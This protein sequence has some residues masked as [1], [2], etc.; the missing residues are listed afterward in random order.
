MEKKKYDIVIIQDGKPVYLGFA[1]SEID[2]YNLPEDKTGNFSIDYTITH[3]IET[4][5]NDEHS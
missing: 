5:D 2:F 3:K 1:Y 4:E